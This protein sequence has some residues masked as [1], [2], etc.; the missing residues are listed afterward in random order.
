MLLFHDM[1]GQ[2]IGVQRIIPCLLDML[3]ILGY[4]ADASVDLCAPD[5]PGAV[6]L[7]DTSLLALT[8]AALR[9]FDRAVEH[10]G[11]RN[12]YQRH[13]LDI[14]QRLPDSTTNYD[15]AE[16]AYTLLLNGMWG[17]V[18]TS[19]QSVEVC[20]QSVD[21][22]GRLG[23]VWGTA[24]AQL[25][26]ADSANWGDVDAELARQSYRAS[27]E[28]FD[29]LGN[30]WGRAMC[31]NGLA[32]IEQ[33]AGHQKEAYRMGS[34]SLDI[35]CRLG[36]PWREV[37]VRQ[38][39]IEVAEAL[40][41]FDEVRRH[42]KANL[43]HFSQ[44]G[45][46]AERDSCLERLAR[47]DERAPAA[48]SDLV[49]DL[50]PQSISTRVAGPPDARLPA[51]ADAPVEPLSAREREVLDLLAAGLTGPATGQVSATM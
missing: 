19:R 33:R 41:A 23:D 48:P 27:L 46:A 1:S 26:L 4:A 49:P 22:F 39:L 6:S 25:I 16:K 36:N 18:L 24:L 43:A 12:L 15:P 9:H 34:Q 51:P 35:S 5:A 3:H 21:I 20:Q 2:A 13:S 38:I 14:V 17:G 11:Q 31:L 30:D 42:L 29:R 7:A 10:A 44:M 37:F 28:G 45:A 32:V 40:G 8:L 47:L 50:Q